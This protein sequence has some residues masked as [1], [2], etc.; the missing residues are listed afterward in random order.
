MSVDIGRAAVQ[1]AL[2]A[3]ALS[4][5]IDPIYALDDI[6]GAHEHQESGQARG[7]ILIRLE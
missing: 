6:A 1:D 3:G 4:P 2:S 5:N 7:K